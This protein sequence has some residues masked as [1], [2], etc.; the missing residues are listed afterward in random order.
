MADG[1]A[2]NVVLADFI[3]ADRRHHSGEHP[4]SLQGILH[5]QRVHDRG[6]HAHVVGRDSIHAFLGQPGPPKQVATTDDHTHFDAVLA[7]FPHLARNACQH[8]GIDAIV[9]LAHQDFTAELEK[10]SL[11]RW[12]GI[13]HGHRATCNIGTE[14]IVL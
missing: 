1:A 12:S 6:Q 7:Q 2:A 8:V 13:Q 4:Q 9:A 11:E 3:D 14:R 5:R 10:N